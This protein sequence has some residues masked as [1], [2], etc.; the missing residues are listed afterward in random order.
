MQNEPSRSKDQ[1]YKKHYQNFSAFAN[2]LRTVLDQ[3]YR[4]TPLLG[5]GFS[6]PAG[7]P[8]APELRRYLAYCTWKALD[9]PHL[10]NS[11]GKKA[12]LGGKSPA[13]ED[14]FSHWNPT[15]EWPAHPNY[16]V[17]E[18]NP[19]DMLYR[20]AYHAID[21]QSPKDP[22][23]RYKPGFGKYYQQG[24]GALA[25]WRQ[26]LHFLSRMRDVHSENFFPARPDASIVDSFF[27]KLIE[28]RYPSLGHRMLLKLVDFLR[29]NTIL[30]TNFDTL[31][32]DTFIQ[33]GR[34]LTAFDVP[35]GTDLPEARLVTRCRRALVKLHGGTHNL[36]ADLSLDGPPGERDVENFLAYLR[37]GEGVK[38]DLDPTQAAL[39]VAGVSAQDVRTRYLLKEA[40]L[41]YPGLRIFWLYFTEDDLKNLNDFH[42]EVQK[43]YEQKRDAPAEKPE[44]IAVQAP[45]IGLVFLEIYLA[46]T[47]VL[48]PAGAFFP[49]SW[50]HPVPPL[51]KPQANSQ[52]A[53]AELIR[54]MT[55]LVDAYA[56]EPSEKPPVMI[57]ELK[58]LLLS[59]LEA[60]P[61]EGYSIIEAQIKTFLEMLLKLQRG[62]PS[63]AAAQIKD[64]LSLLQRT[65]RMKDY[66][67][68]VAK[69]KAQ[70]TQRLEAPP[71]DRRM[72]TF[73]SDD[74]VY[75]MLS[76]ASEIF[77]DEK[78][79]IDHGAQYLWLDVDNISRPADFFLRLIVAIH[80]ATG[81]EDP[82]P[83]IDL[84]T[85]A[86]AKHFALEVMA[87][88]RPALRR[89][90]VQWVIFINATDGWDSDPLCFFPKTVTQQRWEDEKAQEHF[91]QVL[92][93]LLENPD[94]RS[95]FICLHR[96]AFLDRDEKD[97]G[98]F[99]SL[100][101]AT[102]QNDGQLFGGDGD[103]ETND[104]KGDA[105][106][107][108][109]SVSSFSVA[110]TIQQASGAIAS[111]LA[112]GALLLML[113]QFNEVRYDSQIEAVWGNLEAELDHY[114]QPGERPPIRWS[115]LR[116]AL[117]K[118]WKN[119]WWSSASREAWCG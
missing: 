26:T 110:G 108:L 32:E 16:R 69:I 99:K 33:S 9:C 1:N 4:F 43:A 106:T 93:A 86:S 62:N 18:N 90:D 104:D 56:G 98:K 83:D 117:E 39:I 14:D 87:E 11:S 45:D 82:V 20:A 51:I 61:K 40:W 81:I 25:D 58:K 41:R 13:G 21:D 28:G 15:M 3:G 79:R 2:D 88:L 19:Q 71:S 27:L 80:K 17:Y 57:P 6:R 92:D 116:V 111:N 72:L 42:L 60:D 50:N 24:Y 37:G 29:I 97:R 115:E 8:T 22:N 85:T 36:R 34:K 64:I 66:Q 65:S 30:T 74:E 47:S 119:R 31:I 35:V 10:P 89:T 73:G 48:P 84:D 94:W 91:L 68:V 113:T 5:A 112:A 52:E 46:L 23:A 100:E 67:L 107:L 103:Q 7:I 95:V 96:G 49:A 63:P 118:H 44:L 55:D 54:R 78:W 101:P 75:G 77:Y 59:M 105:W 109:R 53:Y 38:S 76:A 114:F 102:S 70:L 12:T